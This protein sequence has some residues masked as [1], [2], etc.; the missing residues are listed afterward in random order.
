MYQRKIYKFEIEL[1]ILICGIRAVDLFLTLISSSTEDKR[2]EIE[3][4]FVKEKKEYEFLQLKFHKGMS[5]SSYRSS[6]SKCDD[7]SIS[8]KEALNNI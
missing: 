6:P 2:I 1:Y 4:N 5:L 3:L 8:K 7:E